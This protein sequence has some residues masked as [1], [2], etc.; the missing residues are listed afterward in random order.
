MNNNASASQLS[1]W[2]SQ[3]L[4]PNRVV[5][6]FG[7]VISIIAGVVASWLGRHLPG[8]HLNTGTAAGTITQ[9]IEFAIGSLI[10]LALQHKWLDGWQKWE[11]TQPPVGA[12]PTLAPAGEYDPTRDMPTK[13]AGALAG[14][15][16]NQ[17]ADGLG[18][19]SDGGR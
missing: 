7:P 6:F 10:T 17:P 4:Q 18:Q 13:L 14:D 8:L 12:A 15:L 5:A 16:S 3:H 19:P 9:G 1:I 11:A 2:L